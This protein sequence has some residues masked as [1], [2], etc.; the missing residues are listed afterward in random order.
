MKKTLCLILTLI[1]IILLMPGCSGGESEGASATVQP[2]SSQSPQANSSD[3]KQAS[4]SGGS[5]SK[6]IKPEQL[7]SKEDAVTLIGESVKAGVSEEYPLLGLSTSFYAPE[8]PDSKSYLQVCLIQQSALKQGSGESGQSGGSGE[9][10]KSGE[11]GGSESGQQKESGGGSGG[12]GG[13]EMSPKT[14]YEGLKKL[15]SDPNTALTGRIGD[16]I[17]ISAQGISILS[18]EHCIVIL[19]SCSDP[20]KAEE[21]LK[22]AGELAISNLKRIQG[23]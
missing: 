18:G 5:E 2:G 15:F 21:A 10:G 23:E 9:S 13:E 6:K 4:G 20:T 1:A 7:I 11:S 22:K 14:L 17:F 19:M 12:S 8:K 16:D 3:S